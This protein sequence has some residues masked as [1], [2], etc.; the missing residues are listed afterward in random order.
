METV[1][2]TTSENFISFADW[3]VSCFVVWADHS[4]ACGDCVLIGSTRE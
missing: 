3:L 1:H 2:P 4:Q